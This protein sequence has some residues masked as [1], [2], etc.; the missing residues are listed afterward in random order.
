MITHPVVLRELHVVRADEIA[1]GLRRLVLGGGQLGEM[2]GNGHRCAAFTTAAFDDHVKVFPPLGGATVLPEQHD[3]HLHWPE[4][5]PAVARDYTV[6]RFDP[7]AGELTVDVVVDHEGPGSTWGRV[8][9]AGDIVHVAGPRTSAAHALDAPRWIVIGDE[10]ALPAIGRLLDERAAA[11]GSTPVELIAVLHASTDLVPALGFAVD[12]DD[13]LHGVDIHRVP[14]P[15]GGA[16]PVEDVAAA[17][18]GALRRSGT[19]VFVWAAAEFDVARRIRAVTRANGV[20]KGR[21]SITHY[22]RRE[23]T[24]DEAAADALLRHQ[25]D[26]ATP[27][28]LRVAATLGVADAIH[29]GATTAAA[30]ATRTG[31]SV[32]GMRALLDYL[33]HVD[34]LVVDGDGY[35]LSPTGDLLRSD[36]GRGWSRRLRRS[37][38]E[39]H[40]DA[41]LAGL[42]VAVR[43]GIAGHQAVFGDHFWATLE[44]RTDL[45]TSFDDDLGRWA[46]A[47]APAIADLPL[48]ARAGHVVDVGGGDG[49]LLGHLLTRWPHLRGTLVEQPATARRAGA[50]LAAAGHRDRVTIAEQSFFDPL[51]PGG[52]VYV[53]AQVLHDWPDDDA[54]LIL[55]GCA[56]AAGTGGRVAIVERLPIDDGGGYQAMNLLMVALFGATERRLEEYS[57]LAAIAGLRVD[58]VHPTP[59]GLHLIDTTVAT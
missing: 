16:E 30:V 37:A 27:W 51:P 14:R 39:A 59:M 11:H 12:A 17:V 42:L 36:H 55:R 43:D 33:V 4:H 56:D 24:H 45:G 21:T 28:A 44:R 25:A 26:L 31:A 23:Q 46:A 1:P 2:V 22:W 57:A 20:D 53:V 10:T 7:A 3:G 19:D 9:A 38:A 32:A 15:V 5:P 49:T 8:A 13:A 47:W 48:W 29:D 50:S 35:H 18:D 34:V 40:L 58:G 41:A 52:D 54:T 6:R